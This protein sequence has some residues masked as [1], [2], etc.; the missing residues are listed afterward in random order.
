MNNIKQI[1]VSAKNNVVANKT[2]ILTTVAVV[3][4][5]IAVIQNAG[6]RQHDDFLKEH[7]LYEEFYTPEEV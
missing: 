4:T 5:T 7:G 3:S 2:R 1:A 6:L